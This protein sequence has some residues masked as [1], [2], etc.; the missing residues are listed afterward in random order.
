MQQVK[1]LFDIIDYQ[2]DHY[3]QTVA[4]A[5]RRNS[6]WRTLSTRDVKATANRISAGLL[7]L[8]VAPGGRIAIMAH[9]RP[10]WNL[11]D[12]G[13]QQIGAIPVPIYPTVNEETCRHILSDSGSS[14]VF[15]E[16]A[17]N[18]KKI[19][20]VRGDVA[21]LE[22]VF[23]LDE[24]DGARAWEAA[25]ADVDADAQAEIDRRKADIQEDDLATIIYT[26]G[27]T[28]LPKG[29]MLSH[30]NM[31]SNIKASSQLAPVDSTHTALSLLPLSHVFERMVNYL[32]ML[33]GVSIYYAESPDTFIDDVQDVRPHMLSIVPRLLEKVHERIMSRALNQPLPLRMIFFWA[34]NLAERYE[35]GQQ[36]WLYRAQ[37]AVADALV[38]R[39]WR[40]AFGGNMLALVSGGAP[41]D[42]RLGRIFTAAG[43][44]VLEGYGLTESSPVLAVNRY[45]PQYRRIGSVGPPLDNVEIRIAE[46]GEILA[47]GPNIM[48][49]Y[50]NNPE[51]TE[52][53]CKDGWLHTGDV[54]KLDDDNFLYVSDRVDNIFKTSG[55]KFVV[56]QHIE[57]QFKQSYLIDQIM[58]VGEDRKMVTAIISP[59]FEN[60][61]Q[62]CA[63]H[64]VPW[65][66]DRAALLEQTAIQQRFDRIVQNNNRHLDDVEQVKRFTLVP[67]TWT[68]EDGELTPSMKV[69]REQMQQRY[70]DTI[71][72]MYEDDAPA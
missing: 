7:R 60:L 2:Q 35:V 21:G 43:L 59:D 9:N 61:R 4:L 50:H 17:A 26:S 37:L 13:A 31:V 65:Q 49:G 53:V 47:R 69:K 57:E 40:E 3:P 70:A 12:L 33:F 72:Q 62:W 14:I 71:A 25:L 20:S 27:T 34:Q 52:A 56:P 18:F 63:D 55:G 42:P 6:G 38:F 44:P 51:A 54:G 22:A 45:D 67:D 8:G 24:I 30:K 66:D 15:V 64:D 58:V 46:N 41:L 48:L 11:I 36:S 5:A 23:G 10:E 16:E 29:V 32:Y 1:R 28:G 39:Q 19:D 68:I